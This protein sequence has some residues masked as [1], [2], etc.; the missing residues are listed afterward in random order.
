VLK[1]YTTEFIELM[2]VYYGVDDLAPRRGDIIVPRSRAIV[3]HL[4]E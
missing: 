4:G 1:E 2:D 3:R